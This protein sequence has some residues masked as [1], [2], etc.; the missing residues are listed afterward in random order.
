MIAPGIRTRP[1]GREAVLSIFIGEAASRTGKVRVERGC[2]LFDLVQIAAGRIGLP[3]FDERI[4]NWTTAIVEHA[5]GNDD[6]LT[7]RL[8]I[9]YRVAGHV[10]VQRLESVAAK[11]G[12]TQLGQGLR[13]AD[14]RSLGRTQNS[15]FIGWM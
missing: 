1:D 14:E 12:T 6:A 10:I 11:Y 4:A 3:D 9:L 8:A 13:E 7:N 15:G 2:V 5:P